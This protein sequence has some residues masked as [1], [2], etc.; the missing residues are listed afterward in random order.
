[1]DLLLAIKITALI[2]LIAFIIVSFFL[3]V[4]FRNILSFFR[5]STNSINKIKS[6]FSKSLNR[7]SD[8][9]ADLKD[10]ISLTLRNVDNLSTSLSDNT[11]DL[12]EIKIKVVDSLSRIDVLTESLKMNSTDFTD[13]KRNVGFTLENIDGLT[14]QLRSTTRNIEKDFSSVLN[15]IKPLTDA[16]SLVKNKVKTP[17]GKISPYISAA[18]KAV[19]TF[20]N[21][22]A[23]KDGDGTHKGQQSAR[24]MKS[25]HD[26]ID[27][28]AQDVIDQVHLPRIPDG[29]ENHRDDKSRRASDNFDV[30]DAKDYDG[31]SGSGDPSGED[32]L[33]DAIAEAEKM[34]SEA[35]KAINEDDTKSEDEKKEI[36]RQITELRDEARKNAEKLRKD[37]YNTKNED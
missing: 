32:L 15:T 9:I 27:L 35:E 29:Y 10:N 21:H 13:L 25:R 6:D 12:N 1:M 23:S 5:E 11:Q 30:V 33:D 37:L 22:V 4:S 7:V 8:D 24:G 31:S 16:I 2:A 18:S 17:Y 36:R 19:S 34:L 26:D 28:D 20:I 14:I 3:M